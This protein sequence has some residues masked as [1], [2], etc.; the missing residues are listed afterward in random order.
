MSL[1]MIR[2]L[3]FCSDGAKTTNSTSLQLTKLTETH[4]TKD[5]YSFMRCFLA[6]QV[7]YATVV[8]LIDMYAD[9]CG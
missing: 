1:Q 6:F 3:W 9:D 8:H 2:K 4:F 5:G 7:M